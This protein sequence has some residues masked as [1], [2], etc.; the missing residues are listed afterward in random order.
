VIS[1][2]A[3]LLV[4]A[5]SV[6]RRRKSLRSLLEEAHPTA[7]LWSQVAGTPVDRDKRPSVAAADNARS[8]AI[9]A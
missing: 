3:L 1:F 8:V 5:R 9:G 7:N 2:Q 6:A 4:G